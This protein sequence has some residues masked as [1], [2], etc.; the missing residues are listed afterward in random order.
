MYVGA[1][2]HTGRARSELRGLESTWQFVDYN[3]QWLMLLFVNI[4]NK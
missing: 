1:L 4:D 3:S 2:Y